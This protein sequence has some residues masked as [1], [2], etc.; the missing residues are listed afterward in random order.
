M[1]YMCVRKERIQ[2]IL[3]FFLT[4]L[5]FACARPQGVVPAVDVYLLQLTRDARILTQHLKRSFSNR[6]KTQIHG[7]S[8]QKLPFSAAKQVL[9]H[10]Q[11]A[12]FAQHC[13]KVVPQSLLCGQV[14]EATRD[15]LT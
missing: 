2:V 10:G 6:L 5:S 3:L 1:T 11:S 7:F 8:T 15:A 12:H 9:L 13:H 14:N 4:R